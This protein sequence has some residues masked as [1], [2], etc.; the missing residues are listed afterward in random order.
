VRPQCGETTTS[1]RVPG[2]F[3]SRTSG[4]RLVFLMV[5]S[6]SLRVRAP[7][8][9]VGSSRAPYPTPIHSNPPMCMRITPCGATGSVDILIQVLVPRAR[10]Q[11]I[12]QGTTSQ[13]P[14]YVSLQTSARTASNMATS[15]CTL[16]CYADGKRDPWLGSARVWR[17]KFVTGAAAVIT[18]FAVASAFQLQIA[19]GEWH[20]GLGLMCTCARQGERVRTLKI[21][22]DLASSV[23]GGLA[24]HMTATW[25]GPSRSSPPPSSRVNLNSTHHDAIAL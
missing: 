1:A 16:M 18:I 12:I 15:S 25:S 23:C 21:V 9:Q 19:D 14:R 13:P 22:A 2:I 6:A 17:A 3:M 20:R 11:R 10:R 5:H 8:W 4:R 24:L 7:R